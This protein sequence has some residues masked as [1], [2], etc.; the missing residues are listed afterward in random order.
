MSKPLAK[1]PGPIDTD[2]IAWAVRETLLAS[3]EPEPSPMPA[4][5]RLWRGMVLTLAM[6]VFLAMLSQWG[7]L[8]GWN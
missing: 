6:I 1:T 2:A 3:R 4:V 5:S 8:M 7:K